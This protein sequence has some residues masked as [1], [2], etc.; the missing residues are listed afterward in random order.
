MKTDD[1]IAYLGYDRS[2]AFLQGE[3]L[4]SHPGFS[5]VFRRAV[6]DSGLRGVYVLRD[7]SESSLVPIVYV[8]EAKNDD[9]A[10][11]IHKHVW[12]QNVVP[13]LL[14]ITRQNIRIYPGFNYQETADQSQ[15]ESNLLL[16]I[17]QT[18]EALE[19]LEAFKSE[20]IDQGAL[21]SSWGNKVTPETRVDEQLLDQLKQLSHWLQEHK[22]DRRTAHALIGKYVYLRYLRDRD[23]LSDNRLKGWQINA[24]TIFGRN[25]HLSAFKKVVSCLDDWLNGSVFPLPN[26]SISSV[27]DEHISKV[28]AIFYGDEVSGQTHLD[29]RRYD[30]AQIPIET[31]SVVY[32]QFLH[33]DDTGR[34]KGA[35]YTPIHL[36]NFMLDELESKRPLSQGMTV[37]DP[38]C[39]SGA[40]LV[41]CYRRLVERCRIEQGKLRPTELRNLLTKHIFGIDKDGDACHVASLSL[42]MTLLDYI[43]PPDLKRYSSFKIPSLVG[44]NIIEGDFFDTD[45]ALSGSKFD[46]I[47]GNPPWRK[48]SSEKNLK[49]HDRVTADW[50]REHSAEYPVGSRQLAEL[51]AWK[52]IDYIKANSLVALL[53][54]AMT[55]FKTQ[56]ETF[57]SRFF[58]HFNVWAVA[59]FA[60]LAE[61]LFAGRSRIP[62]AAFFYT[63]INERNDQNLYIDI[64][65]PFLA[66]QETHLGDKKKKQ[67]TTWNIIINGGEVRQVHIADAISGDSLSW[68]IAMWGSARDAKLLRRI[69]RVFPTLR[70]FRKK[71]GISL[72]QG[73]ELRNANSREAIEFVN[74]LIDKKLINMDKLRGHERLFC[75]PLSVFDSVEK[76]NAYVRKRGG[77]DKPLSICRPPHIFVDQA[78]R[79]GFYSDEYL[80]IP[81]PQVGI[82]G[83]TAD[84]DLLKALALFLNSKFA[85][86]FQFYHSVQWGVQK[87]FAN[88]ETLEELPIPLN[89]LGNKEI[90]KW[91]QLHDELAEID[92][93]FQ[94]EQSDNVLMDSTIYDNKRDILLGQLNKLVYD[95]LEINEADRYLVEDLI[96]YR[97][98]L[99]QGKLNQD[100]MSP[101]STTE[102][103]AYAQVMCKELDSFFDDDVTYNHQIHVYKDQHYGVLGITLNN[104]HPTKNTVSVQNITQELSQNLSRLR[105]Q[106]GPK[107][108]QWIYFDRNLTIFDGPRTYLLKPMQRLHWLRSQALSDTDNLIADILATAVDDEF[109]SRLAANGT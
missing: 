10:R 81:G 26:K 49:P 40:F 85:L 28:A 54:P 18:N 67:P 53:I 55:L 13:F 5:Y 35:Y 14:V 92:K 102:L 64:Y 36:V 73:P 58:S 52:S 39:G 106:L 65:T 84:A 96:H 46:W 75:L 11:R 80:I 104:N 27:S 83:S 88:K 90:E 62:A 33:E 41:Q 103:K 30:F 34:D 15:H 2:S 109:T 107:Y 59:N 57:R 71:H 7:S 87:S 21:W 47:V 91:V 16:L 99:N 97:L 74:E 86:Y 29:F 42:V 76:K 68:K 105:E 72:Y 100:L 24:D 3:E 79:F 6:Q 95:A 89:C 19:Q 56:S 98:L 32:E 69:S 37:L 63:T 4:N 23:I 78:R 60:N 1:V 9:E 48:V 38:A 77:I 31:L 50:I 93:S 101:P 45:S 51:F 70:K 20:A 43:S 44:E 17:E 22:L 108:G 66:N 12:N 82:S 61:V 8:C 94:C 25:A